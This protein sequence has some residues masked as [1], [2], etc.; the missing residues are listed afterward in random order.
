MD[1]Y[2]LQKLKEYIKGLSTEDSVPT[3]V[4]VSHD[5][6]DP[7]SLGSALG[8]QRL[9]KFWNPNI[10]TVILYGGEISH[11]QNK[12]MVNILNINPV[13]KQDYKETVDNRVFIV[14]DSIPDRSLPNEECL[15]TIDHHKGDT[16]KSKYKDIR[17][18]GAT[19][20]IVWDYFQ[21]EGLELDNTSDED[22]DVATALVVG[23]KTDTSDLSSDNVTD[24]DFDAYKHL[25]GFVNQRKLALIIKYPLPPYHFELR[26]RLDQEGNSMLDNGVF[27]GGIGYIVPSKRDALPTIAEERSRV[28]GTDTAII[29]AIVGDNIE[30]SVRSNGLSLDVN[31]I[32][33]NLF[34]KEYGGGKMGAGATRCPMGVLSIEDDPPEIQDKMWIAIRAKMQ[35]KILAEMSRYR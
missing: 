29:F 2:P 1:K 20:S 33:Q 30:V 23:I 3:V 34:G 5:N 14:V 17:L 35:H 19:S 8:M 32:C 21:K 22:M 11:P 4:I 31:A 6:P 10:K 24:L 7:D 15:Y 13:L 25:I 28:E 27:I 18:V 9:L 12:T 16:R 26:S